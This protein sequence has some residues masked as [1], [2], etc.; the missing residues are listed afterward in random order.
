[1]SRIAPDISCAYYFEES[2]WRAGYMA[3]TRNREPLTLAPALSEMMGYI[4]KLGGY[5]ERKKD[6]PRGIKAIWIGIC[7]LHN[8]ADAWDLFD[9][10]ATAQ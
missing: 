9:P 10:G 4:A 8:Y 1:M 2:E 5:L 3:A 6:L 7:K